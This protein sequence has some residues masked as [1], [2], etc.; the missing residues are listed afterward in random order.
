MA[1]VEIKLKNTDEKLKDT[2]K[3]LNDIR[4][5]LDKDKKTG[6]KEAGELLEKWDV[7]IEKG[8]E[9][10]KNEAIKQ[11]SAAI[12]NDPAKFIKSVFKGLKPDDFSYSFL[13]DIYDERQQLIIK[14]LLERSL[15]PLVKL[16][17]SMH[18]AKDIGEQEQTFKNK[19]KE[20]INKDDI[21]NGDIKKVAEWM[22][23]T[24]LLY[25][26]VMKSAAE[27]GS[28]D[29]ANAR[30]ILQNALKAIKNQNIKIREALPH[31]ESIVESKDPNVRREALPIL[32]KAFQQSDVD[33]A[34]EALPYLK[35][36][37]VKTYEDI[38]KQN[39]D[40]DKQN[41][42]Q[43]LLKFYGAVYRGQY[44]FAREEVHKFLR[45]MVKPIELEDLEK[46]LANAS[47]EQNPSSQPKE[48]TSN[49]AQDNNQEKK[50]G[51][52]QI[53]G[54]AIKV[55]SEQA[56][57]SELLAEMRKREA[58]IEKF[59]TGIEKADPKLL[60]KANASILQFNVELQAILNKVDLSDKE[61][62]QLQKLQ[63][64]LNSAVEAKA[65]ELN[66]G[67]KTLTVSD[68]HLKAT[69]DHIDNLMKRK[70]EEYKEVIKKYHDFVVKIFAEEYGIP[71][72]SIDETLEERI[73]RHTALGR[74]LR[75]RS[76][77]ESEI[78]KTAEVFD[79]NSLNQ[80]K[81]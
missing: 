64:Q 32:E 62:E 20:A 14:S 41:L 66:V 50:E 23:T 35:T 16:A 68:K 45:M 78:P 19:L 54:S 30:E 26:Y 11:I 12:K 76:K 17:R 21:E 60:Q 70:E 80:N 36:A 74:L 18:L 44:S 28:I 2:E 31:L 13:G 61:G 81:Q 59:I 5:A 27:K 7:A 77:G 1:I 53:P 75:N 25:E 10:G 39:S 37:L 8:K 38:L 47:K 40:T 57:A 24:K 49:E 43:D 42:F 71:A 72:E 52:K 9:D 6:D 22:T 67:T 15:N 73:S 69:E 65:K 56:T 4:N 46:Q 51:N 33:V 58:S 55:F 3:K 48:Q 34:Q 79:I 29:P 63:E